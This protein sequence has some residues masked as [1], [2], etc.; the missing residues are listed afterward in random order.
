MEPIVAVVPV[1]WYN[2]TSS[3]LSQI[4]TQFMLYLPRILAA[5]IIFLIGVLIAKIV[6]NVLIK[7]LEA[8]RLSSLV[9]NTPIEHFFENAELGQRIEVIIG[10]IA[11]WLVMLIV[12]QA[13]VGILGLESVSQLLGKI[14]AY[15]PN[16]VSAIL[17]LFFGVLIAG[18]A[19]SI[20]KGSI[21]TI[22]GRSSRM[23]GKIAS[24]LVMTLAIMAAVSELG[25]ASEFILILFIGFVA[26]LSLGFGLAIGLGG[27]E[28]VRKVLNSWYSKTMDDVRE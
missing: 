12:L 20:V 4:G 1:E 5:L 19:E 26:M 28:M 17:V 7:L 25:I 13:S 6:K 22:D 2:S 3:F 23:L 14:L 27:Q 8:L 16:V 21:K 9:K 10:T 18:A 15:L 11:Y 24:Y